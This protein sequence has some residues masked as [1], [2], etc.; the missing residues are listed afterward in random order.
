MYAIV[1]F[2]SRNESRVL[3]YELFK[4]HTIPNFEAYSNILIL[5]Q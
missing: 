2:V 3:C 4:I 5:F 1:G